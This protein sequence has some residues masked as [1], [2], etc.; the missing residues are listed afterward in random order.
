MTDDDTQQE[1]RRVARRA[2][3]QAINEYAAAINTDDDTILSTTGGWVVAIYSPTTEDGRDA[4]V[5]ETAEG[6]PWH[7]SVGLTRYAVT[8]WECE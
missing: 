4:Y 5:T 8:H 2:L 7:V 1:A 3:D 6:Q